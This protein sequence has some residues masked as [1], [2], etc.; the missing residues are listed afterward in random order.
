MAYSKSRILGYWRATIV[1]QQVPY[2]L[3]ERARLSAH[4]AHPSRDASREQQ[5]KSGK[6]KIKKDYLYGLTS[7]ILCK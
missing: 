7:F 1:L 5:S 3:W 4:A 6:E 2:L